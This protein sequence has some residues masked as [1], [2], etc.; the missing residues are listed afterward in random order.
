M[1]FQHPRKHIR[2]VPY[3]ILGQLFNVLKF[4]QIRPYCS[5]CSIGCTAYIYQYSAS[6]LQTWDVINL[7]RT[8]YSVEDGNHQNGN[9]DWSGSQVLSYLTKERPDQANAELIADA[10]PVSEAS[11]QVTSGL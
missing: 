1:S 2:P 10:P 3:I 6:N 9:R 4:Y 8:T 7:E 5:A 11:E